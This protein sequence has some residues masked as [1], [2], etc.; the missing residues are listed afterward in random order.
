MVAAGLVAKKAVERGLKVP[1][2]VKTSLSPGSRVVT[3][4]FNKS[5]LNVYLDQLGFQTTGY[6]CMTC[7]G[8]SGRCQRRSATPWKR[9]IWSRVRC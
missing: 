2:T 4:Y 3:E 5:G 8:N 6:G 1:P 9:A 7:I